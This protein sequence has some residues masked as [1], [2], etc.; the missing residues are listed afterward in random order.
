MINMPTPVTDEGDIQLHPKEGLRIPIRFQLE[1]GSPRDMTGSTVAF[2]VEPG[3]RILLEAGE[4]SD[5]LMLVINKGA[6]A[7]GRH[8]FAL[9]EE[10][11][12]PPSVVWAG[13]IVVNPFA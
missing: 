4:T 1:D 8:R 12:L 10:T 6:I 7:E 9:V 11:A 2:E 3:T 13:T 5:E